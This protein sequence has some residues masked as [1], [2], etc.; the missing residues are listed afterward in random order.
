MT[1]HWAC[2]MGGWAA[3]LVAFLFGWG[4]AKRLR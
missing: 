1:D 3:A 2:L 4:I